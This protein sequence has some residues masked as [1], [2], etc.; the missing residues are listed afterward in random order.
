[1]IRRT[2]RIQLVAFMLITVLGIGYAG[3]QYVGL[4]QKF[5]N[6]PFTVTAVF[7]NA[8]NIYPNAEVTLRGVQV[9]QV[10]SVDLSGDREQVKVKLAIKNSWKNKIPKDGTVPVVANLS[11]VGELFVDL[12]PK[13]E[14]GPY[15]RDG[16]ELTGGIIPIPNDVLLKNLDRLVNSV[17]KKQ[18]AS[19]IDLLDIAFADTGPDISRL[20]ARGD[21]LT[22]AVT[23]ALPQTVQLINDG[24]IV[25]DT[26]RY[27]AANFKSFLSDLAKLSDT[28]RSDDPTY[29][30]LIDNGVKSAQQLDSLLK[31]N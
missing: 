9:G 16:D 22:Q 30:L 1:V 26:Q 21:S 10:K 18:L 29:R 3:F 15:L 12:Q 7:P 19:V 11:A 20:I 13:T 2:V 6:K 31:E 25:L 8:G 5:I 24:K 17:D 28:I 14:S 23:D 27:V 4:G